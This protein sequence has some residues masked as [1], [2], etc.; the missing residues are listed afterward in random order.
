MRARKVD[1]GLTEIVKAYRKM[2]WRVYVC[3][4]ALC[5][6]IIQRGSKTELIEV[7]EKR[8]SFTDLQKLMRIRGWQIRTVRSV[9]DIL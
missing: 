7:K 2:G 4:D 1:A 6:I 5:D 8:G 9:E 3:N